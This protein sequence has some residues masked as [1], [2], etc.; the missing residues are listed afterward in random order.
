MIIPLGNDSFPTTGALWWVW[1]GCLNPV[2]HPS[3]S[4]QERAGGKGT[5]HHAR[6]MASAIGTRP[7]SSPPKAVLH[8]TALALE[9]EG[10][11]DCCLG[12]TLAFS[13]QGPWI[14]E[15]PWISASEQRIGPFNSFSIEKPWPKWLK[16]WA[17]DPRW[18]SQS[19][20]LRFCFKW[21]SGVR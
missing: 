3:W 1:Q 8:P 17:P 19:L 6:V 12:I 2:A 18:A 13:D 4:L 16:R 5:H 14:L 9:V 21:L 7:S 10:T 20:S 11:V 15:M